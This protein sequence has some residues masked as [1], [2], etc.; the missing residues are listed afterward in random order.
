[1]AIKRNTCWRSTNRENARD[2]ACTKRTNTYHQRSTALSLNHA[3]TAA[4]HRMNCIWR[5]KER[6]VATRDQLEVVG[7]QFSESERGHEAVTPSNRADHEAPNAVMEHRPKDDAPGNIPKQNT[8]LCA[9]TLR[10]QPR[11]SSEGSGSVWKSVVPCRNRCPPDQ[12]QRYKE[13]NISTMLRTQ[14]KTKQTNQSK[15]TNAL[16][17]T[18]GQ[19]AEGSPP[20][21]VGDQRLLNTTK[22][23]HTVRQHGRLFQIVI[24][25]KFVHGVGQ[26]RFA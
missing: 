10:G 9:Q 18:C 24:F 16:L 22:Q 23:K 4:E 1:M 13:R 11:D 21:R 26:R 5:G 15:P 8:P 17:A 7:D 12:V 2:W 19:R 14:G 20:H 6:K 25:P 3:T